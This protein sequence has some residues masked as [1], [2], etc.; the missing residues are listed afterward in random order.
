LAALHMAHAQIQALKKQP[1]FHSKRPDLPV[2]FQLYNLPVI[3]RVSQQKEHLLIEAHQGFVGAPP[4]VIQALVRIALGGKGKAVLS[5]VKDY[6]HSQAFLSISS[7]LEG[8]N[9]RAPARTQGQQFD[10]QQVFERVNQA[11][12]HG[13]MERPNLTWNKTLT[14]RKF[15]HYQA[16]TD[17]VM[18][19][20]SLDQA[21]TP[22]YVVEFVMYHE[23]LHKQLGVVANRGRRYAHTKAFREAEARFPKQEQAQAY[24][25][26][27]SAKIGKSLE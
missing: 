8:E 5:K 9:L 19:S 6:A 23:L 21:S 17:T 7:A 15:G 12:F 26:R 25:N 24:L 20:I 1:K 13:Q 10:L 27:L 2:R 22:V 14:H 11:Y 3:Y 16:N 4:E 18:L